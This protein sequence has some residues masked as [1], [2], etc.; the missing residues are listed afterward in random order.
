MKEGSFKSGDKSPLSTV[1]FPSKI[2]AI[3]REMVDLFDVKQ[4]IHLKVIC[5]VD[6]RCTIYLY[7][8]HGD[9]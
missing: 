5:K 8:L 1:H 6:G 4:V 9:I 3:R 7:T 2:G